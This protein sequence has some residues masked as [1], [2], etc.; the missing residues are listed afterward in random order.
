MLIITI[1]CWFQ[2]HIPL[3]GLA[4]HPVKTLSLPYYLLSCFIKV[5]AGSHG[6]ERRA[7]A[8]ATAFAETSSRKARLRLTMQSS[9]KTS[10]P[11]LSINVKI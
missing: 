8:F 6:T 5:R 2:P 1:F 10:C 7:L 3:Y 9:E 11:S 4:A